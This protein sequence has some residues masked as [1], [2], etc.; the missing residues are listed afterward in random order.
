MVAFY[1]IYL[2]AKRALT[3]VHV[4]VNEHLYLSA[5]NSV[6]KCS[7]CGHLCLRYELFSPIIQDSWAST[8][9]VLMKNYIKQK[10]LE[11]LENLGL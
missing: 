5:Q 10:T 11:L 7:I 9:G 1:Q 3:R 8:I 4:P 2:S 6:T